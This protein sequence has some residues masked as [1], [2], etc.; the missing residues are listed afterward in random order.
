MKKGAVAKAVGLLLI[1]SSSFAATYV[2]Q[3][4]MYLINNTGYYLTVQVFLASKSL[5]YSYYY[6]PY[7]IPPCGSTI[8]SEC[9]YDITQSPYYKKGLAYFGKT[10]DPGVGGFN[11]RSAYINHDTQ[12]TWGPEDQ[13][14]CG[15]ANRDNQ[16]GS[17]VYLSLIPKSYGS[18]L[19]FDCEVS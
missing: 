3:S 19:I 18:P 14:Y 11:V 17:T 9:T 8:T 4:D 15:T 7:T 1:C 2:K 5:A 13:N 10:T 16:G 12:Y 6:P